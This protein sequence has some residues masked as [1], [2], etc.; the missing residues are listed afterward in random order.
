MSET[1]DRGRYFLVSPEK[2]VIPVTRKFFETVEEFLKP[3]DKLGIMEVTFK[4]GGICAI[5]KTEQIL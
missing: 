4:N 3:N 2:K 5:K 1:V